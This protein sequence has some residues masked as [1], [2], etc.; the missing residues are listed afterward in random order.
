MRKYLATTALLVFAGSANAMTLVSSTNGPDMGPAANQHIIADFSS[1]AGLT[2]SYTLATG[3]VSSQ[4]AAPLGDSTQ[5]L[6]VLAGQVASLAIS[7]AVKTLSFYWGSIDNYN[8]VKFFSGGTE[9]GSFTGTQVPPA[10]ADGSQGN[11]LNNRRVFFSF[12]GAKV[13]SVQFS[14]SQN[15]FE[16]DNV[17]AAV[18]EPATWA[19]LTVGFGLVGASVRRRHSTV[20]AA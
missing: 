20:V 16:L 15:A 6:A 13:D 11:P 4:Y 2:G 9:V 14:S 17:A 18:P 1:A 10:P 7:P 5:Y 8:T 12:D 3:S 19:L